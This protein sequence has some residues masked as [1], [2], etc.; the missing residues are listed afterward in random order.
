MS[1]HVALWHQELET[2]GRD[3]AAGLCPRYATLTLARAP[4][5]QVHTNAGHDPRRP[6]RSEGRRRPRSLVRR[7]RYAASSVLETWSSADWAK[8]SACRSRR[9]SAAAAA[10]RRLSNSV[11]N[12]DRPRGRASLRLFGLARKVDLFVTNAT[13]QV[14]FLREEMPARLARCADAGADRHAVF[15]P[16]PPL[17]RQVETGLSS[18]ASG[19]SSGTTAPLPRRRGDLD[20]DVRV[21]GFSRDAEVEAEV[22][23]DPMPANMTRRFYPWPE[24]VQLYRDADS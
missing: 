9:R 17:G 18:P 13:A 19:W 4:G 2:V 10:G 15:Y 1:Y 11:H 24:L 20:V 8:T 22:F 23:P 14:D 3:A 16:R 12:L 7:G 6:T 21:S 5:A